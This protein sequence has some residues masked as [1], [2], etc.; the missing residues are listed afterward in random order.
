MKS[1]TEPV[2]R[3]VPKLWP[4]STI[5]C[6][7]CG[8]SLSQED[9]DFCRDRARVIAVKDTWRLAPWADV[10]YACDGKWWDFYKGV[11]EFHG[12]KF[13]LTV[14]GHWP[15]VNAL[16]NTGMDGLER[17]PSGLRTGQN[18]GYQAINLAVHLGATRI[19]LL[20]Y[21]MQRVKGKAH[22]Y[23]EHLGTGYQH[24]ASP[25]HLFLRCFETIGEP[26]QQLGIEV[27]NC[28]PQTALTM[29]PCQSIREALAVEPVLVA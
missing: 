18:S 28:S 13:G 7:G 26:L 6:L 8:P 21:D 22:W 2:I 4:E 29:F 14:D 20:G 1:K 11:P 15:D 23:G 5:I 27:I 17:D 3:P 24:T 25:Y 10:L 12:L 9:I 19:L 16:R